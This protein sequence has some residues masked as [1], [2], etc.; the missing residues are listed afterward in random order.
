MRGKWRSA[1]CL[2]LAILV[3]ASCG[4]PAKTERAAAPTERLW[5][6]DPVPSSVE[7]PSERPIEVGTEFTVAS[8]GAIN[9]VRFYQG[10]HTTADTAS[11]WKS[12]GTKLATA[13]IQEGPSGWREI[14]FDT[15]VPVTAD[16]TYVV[17]Y[18]SSNGH[19]ANDA[20]TFSLGKTVKSGWLVA[21]GGVFRDGNGFPDQY[22]KGRNYFVDVIFQSSGPTTRAVDGGDQF[23]ASFKNTFPTS[24]DFFL[25]G[26]WY[27]D[28]SRP[29]EIEA[30]RALGLNTYV[31]LTD[32]S[33]VQLIK[34]SGMF[35]LPNK[36]NPN[37]AGQFLIDEADMWAGPGDAEWSGKTPTD[38][39]APAGSTCI[40]AESKCGYT[41]MKTVSSEVATGVLAYANYGK[42]VTFWQTRE[43]AARFIN[44]FQNVV[45]ADNYW[46]TD[47]RI[48]R[49]DEGGALKRNGEAA[50]TPAECHLAANYGLT[51][52]Y[53]RSLVQPRAAMPVWNFVELGA[54]F[55]DGL[56]GTITGPQM[57]AA[58]WSS[59]INGARGIVYFVHNLGGTCPTM[60]LL[61]DNCGDAIRADLT[62][63]NKQITELAPVL[64][65][66]FLDGYARTDG[67]I[68][69][70]VKRYGGD[71]YI[72]AGATQ[73][74][75][76]DVTITL[77]CGSA[78]SAEVI[79]ENRT[80][81]ITDLKFRDS[82]AD[83]NAVH[84]YKIHTTEGCEAE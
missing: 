49:A 81:P 80:V 73:D 66:P 67:P 14:P 56:G 31:M 22:G 17:S 60:N 69:L 45:S 32:N 19:Y 5:P 23:Y 63:V 48:C 79:G 65:A 16:S 75:P 41:V 6:S 15:P 36:P 44:D 13:A 68:D 54:P 61:R 55:A 28:T 46:F 82:F 37:A 29:Q 7:D 11:L 24:P 70:A 62:A 30:D 39:E 42:G 35:A 83:G 71:D 74:A 21:T 53:V 50:L 47:D 27:T 40:P 18:H 38:P 77:S 26:V 59:I 3:V 43:E 76:T 2:L 20:D 64:N 58:V 1:L 78:D 33:N 4:R 51:T 12:D 34:E 52:R 8:N 84:I 72:L 9:A 57:R 10:P 25:L